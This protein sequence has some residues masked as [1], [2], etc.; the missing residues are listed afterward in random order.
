MGLS[1]GHL[2]PCLYCVVFTVLSPPKILDQGVENQQKC[3]ALSLFSLETKRLRSFFFYCDLRSS[4]HAYF[5]S[6]SEE[7]R[8]SRVVSDL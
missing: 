6:D 1:L 3:Y 4:Y 2:F 7:A 8:G 5:V